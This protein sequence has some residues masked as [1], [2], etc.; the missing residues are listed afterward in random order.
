VR[1]TEAGSL[2]IN[3]RLNMRFVDQLECDWYHESIPR[4]HRQLRNIDLRQLLAR[5]TL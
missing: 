3:Q 4:F 1:G 2:R 5:N